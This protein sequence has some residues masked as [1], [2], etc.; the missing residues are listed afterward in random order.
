VDARRCPRPCSCGGRPAGAWGTRSG[1]DV[2]PSGAPHHAWRSSVLEALGVAR[3][4]TAQPPQTVLGAGSLQD[5]APATRGPRARGPLRPGRPQGP[6]PSNGGM[7]SPL[8]AGRA[9]CPPGAAPPPARRGVARGQACGGSPRVGG[10]RHPAWSLRHGRRGVVAWPRRAVSARGR[11]RGVPVTAWGW[12][13]PTLW[14]RSHRPRSQEPTRWSG[15]V[16]GQEASR[17]QGKP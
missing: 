17:R 13:R 10:P 8:A 2:G 16:P 6:G 14:R 12:G 7:G 1:P 11:A 5:L 15:A 4:G 3:R 9:R